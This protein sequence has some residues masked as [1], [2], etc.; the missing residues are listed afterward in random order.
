MEETLHLLIMYTMLVLTLLLFHKGRKHHRSLMLAIYAS[1]EVVTNG[2]NSLTLSAGWTFFDRFPFSHFI[3]KPIYTLW[4]PLFYFYYR[5]CLS[6][7][8]RLNKKHW[9]H[10]IPAVVFFLFFI[11]V[12][13]ITGNH[14]IWENLYRK[15]T[16]VYLADFAVDIMVKIQYIF[17]IALMVGSLLKLENQIK[18]EKPNFSIP[19]VDI[20]WLRFIVYGYAIGAFGG[21][22]IFVSILINSQATATINLVSIS[23]F[24]L[25]F[26]AIFYNSITQKSFEKEEQQKAPAIPDDEMENLMQ[27]VDQIVQEKQMYLHP[28]LNLQQIAQAVGE[29]ERTISQAI[30]TVKKQNVNEYI[31]SFRI[32]H[33]CRL[34]LENKEKPVF[35]V[36]YESG[37][38]TKGA[39]NLVFKK[40]TG[41]TPTHYRE[42][43]QA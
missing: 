16:F 22:V 7:S 31:N 32:G 13:T 29:K 24:F 25:F 26:F 34:L 36:M 27:V 21:I 43:N 28:E 4:V 11:S 14:Y 18:N 5:S 30:N 12:W 37:F 10:F 15:N 8:F 20:Q 9:P 33:A 3:Y 19:A 17:Y 39:F 42:T 1:V 38:S 40:I 23:Y 2:L 6:S 35:E 41:K